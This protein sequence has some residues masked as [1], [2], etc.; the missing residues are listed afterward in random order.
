[1]GLLW[2][3]NKQI[4]KQSFL[5]VQ[6][7]HSNQQ[8]EKRPLFMFIWVSQMCPRILWVGFL[9]SFYEVLLQLMQK[10]VDHFWALQISAAHKMGTLIWK[11]KWTDKGVDKLLIKEDWWLEDSSWWAS[12]HKAHLLFHNK[13]STQASIPG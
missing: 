2:L 4:P 8:Q 6:F 5:T 9:S 11:R 10:S 3:F 1:M 13:V 12:A 7:F